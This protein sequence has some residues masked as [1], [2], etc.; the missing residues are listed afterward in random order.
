ME[1]KHTPGRLIYAKPTSVDCP[2]VGNLYMIRDWKRRAWKRVKSLRSSLREARKT[3]GG[4]SGAIRLQLIHAESEHAEA[5]LAEAQVLRVI[6]AR[7]NEL[8]LTTV[9]SK[10]S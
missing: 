2:S 8:G 4:G 9:Q 6:E 1:A 5:V 7:A 10:G 3:L